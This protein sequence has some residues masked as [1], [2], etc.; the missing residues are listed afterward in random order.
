MEKSDLPISQIEPTL[1]EKLQTESRLVL[2][3]PTGSGKST[4]VP[5]MLLEAGLLGGGQVK[6]LQPRRLPTRLLAG[7]VARSRGSEVGGEV[8]YQMR[9]DNVTSPRTKICYLTEGVLLRQMLADPSLKDVSAIIFDEFHERHLYGDITLARAVQI[10][11]A[12]RPDLLIVVMSATLDVGGLEKYLAPCAVISATG[13]NYPVEIE[14][15]AQTSGGAPI[16]QLAVQELKRLVNA[17]S[18]G[19]ALIFM[20][21]AYEIERTVQ[22]A[23]AA[24]GPGFVVFPLHGEL[25]SND[26]DAALA[27]YAKRKVVVATNV[28]E[29][30][31]TIDGVRLVVDSGLARVP[32]YDP[33]RGINTLLIE[34]I[35]RA[36]ADQR[37]GRA[38]RTAPGICLRLWT[39]HE[40]RARAAHELPEVRRLDLSE[41]VLTLKASGV[42]DIK[43][44][45]WLEAPDAR[46][47]ERSE[48]LLADLGA[49][50]SATGEITP[51]GR[52]MLAFP[53]H[54]RY[55][56][57]L[58]AAQE[59]GCVR[60]VALIAALMQGRD[61][62]ARRRDGDDEWTA[63]ET[64]SDFFLLMRA[65]RYAEQHGFQMER[66][67]RGG[68][69][70]QAARQAGPLFRQFLRIAADEGL[71]TGE[72]PLDRAAVQRCLLLAFSDQLAKRI[73]GSSRRCELVHGRRGTLTRESVVRSP[74]FVVAEAREVESSSGRERNLN[75]VLNLATAVQEAWLDELFP[76]QSREI[77]SVEY[78]PG[79]K[80]VVARVEKRFRDLPLEQSLS[81]DPPAD[82]AAALL[83][84]EIIAGRLAL[85]RW[86]DGVEQWILRVNRLR[87]WMPELNLPGIADE[88]RR[89]IIEH[90]CH[91]ARSYHQI[92]DRPVL[93]LVKAWLSR[94][95]Q[96]WVEQYA[97]ERIKLPKGRMI[98][99]DYS[100]EAAPT[101][102]ARIQDLY[103]IDDGLWI[104]VRRVRIRVQVLAPSNRPVQITE[105]LGEFWRTTYPQLKQQLQRRYPKHEWR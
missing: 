39:A 56:R 68:I 20:P 96:A 45:R 26:Q 32:R 63:G 80:R 55:A 43:A 74:L 77:R 57:M 90:I 22:E 51:L 1:L 46:A 33:Y 48:S 10:Q 91:G 15:L 83:A 88:D 104:A 79:L 95:Q 93:P 82:E 73:D 12:T 105:N 101:I 34:K 62:R 38:G 84:R 76:Q 60:D 40:H 47:L 86:D 65:W 75:V 24:L 16:W 100:S 71:D 85:E 97:P 17:H 19:D 92:K 98:K 50:D 52:S 59:L 103:G 4:Q 14:Y 94:Q 18:E 49:V 58:L 67:R 25:P 42:R 13:R 99:V 102:A 66:C 31:L 69:N 8:G 81:D 35:S 36:A 44:F 27:R 53:A 89:V 5:Q 72:R 87:E 61:L 28:A 21:G 6:I 64:E 2:S 41:V 7:W 29:T 11:E 78:D 23:R 9:L 54:P 37:A 70:P 3:A 30:S